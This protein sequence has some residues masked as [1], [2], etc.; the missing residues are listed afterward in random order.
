MRKSNSVAHLL[1]NRFIRASRISTVHPPKPPHLSIPRRWK[2][3]SALKRFAG[4]PV[5]RIAAVLVL[6]AITLS[7]QAGVREVGAIGLTVGDLN[8]E[9]FFFTNTLPFELISVSETTGKTQDALLG[10]S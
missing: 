7:A 5:N 8:R 1:L 6:L 10:L 4:A 9:L 2:F 3:G